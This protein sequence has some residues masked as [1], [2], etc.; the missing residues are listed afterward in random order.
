MLQDA[1]RR[2]AQDSNN[3]SA[4]A[5]AGIAA[6]D[7]GD[8]RAA[9]GFL[10]K[11]D[12]IFPNSGRVKAGLARALLAEE[13]PFGALRY[14]DEAVSN[15]VPL[16]NIAADRGLAYDLIGR[17]KDAQK[18][19]ELAL[20]NGLD[21]NKLLTRYAISLGISGDV[22]AAEIKLAPMI[23]KSDRDAWRN[24][25]FIFAM[26]GRENDANDIARQT[27][28]KNMAKAIKPFFDRMPKLTAA[29]KAAA[30]HFGHFPAGEN[31]GVDV[32]TVQYA[33][34]NSIRGIAGA[35]AGLIPL[36]EPLGE[37]SKSKTKIIPIPD[38]KPRENNRLKRS[39]DVKQIASA[40]NPRSKRTK[41][42]RQQ[43]TALPS[44]DNIRAAVQPVVAQITTSIA[45]NILK[46]VKEANSVA[47]GFETVVVAQ[48]TELPASIAIAS[49]PFG[50]EPL[51]SETVIRKVDITGIQNNVPQSAENRNAAQ[52][53]KAV[54]L[55]RTSL[56][57]EGKSVQ[58]VNFDLAKT[59]ISSGVTSN[60]ALGES[61]RKPLADI[62]GSLTI[63]DEEKKSDVVPVDLGSITPARPEVKPVTKP[64]LVKAELKKTDFKKSASVKSEVDHP[65]RY[66]VQ[67]A[68]GSNLSA[69]NYDYKKITKKYPELF[70]GVEGW[71]SPWGQTRRLVVGP[72]SEIK[73]AKN[74][75][76]DFKKMGN[77]GFVWM[78]ADGIEV[79]K[80]SK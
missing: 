33:A 11:A 24:R 44:P 17:N 36:G 14:F 27:M 26:N 58:L 3:S 57:V 16:K 77:D 13:N 12:Q 64:E 75:E 38:S 69:L 78:S 31:I 15:G 61:T 54:E 43:M 42:V 65:K 2:I 6:L 46:P 28:E 19:Y 49:E 56:P 76:F 80:L 68:T 45:D 63:P 59:S 55:E 1:L 23:Q 50:A 10:A 51:I 71:T 7:L 72:F 73:I 5:D 60:V 47:P 41:I 67:V 4:L 34:N 53:T 18:D 21:D 62:I 48:K 22:S 39:D 40:Y 9:I 20:K 37:V 66:W 79:N 74:F 52:F 25:A 35:D 32:A 30:V 70:K 8:T 29:Q